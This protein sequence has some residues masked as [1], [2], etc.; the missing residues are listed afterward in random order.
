MAREDKDEKLLIE[1][2]IKRSI[3]TGSKKGLASAKTTI[4]EARKTDPELVINVGF[5]LLIQLL[6]F[7]FIVML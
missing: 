5:I 6:I 2:K 4:R 1:E 7:R 3:V